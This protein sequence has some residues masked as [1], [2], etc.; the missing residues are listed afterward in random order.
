M[1]CL[2]WLIFPFKEFFVK[3]KN[4]LKNTSYKFF[5]IFSFALLLS[6]Y[7]IFLRSFQ[8]IVF[9]TNFTQIPSLNRYEKLTCVNCGTQTTKHNVARHKKR[10]SVGPLYCS[11]WPNFSTI[12]QN[13]LSYHIAKNTVFQDLEKHTIV[14]YVRQNFPAFVLYVNRE[15]L[16][17]DHKWDLERVMLMWSI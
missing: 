17:M 9:L 16:N 12:L 6:R 10:C 14:N 13:D 2:L 1:S 5:V 4:N 7:F 15:T 11:Q 3:G 8:I